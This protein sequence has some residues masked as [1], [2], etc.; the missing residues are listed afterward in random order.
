[1]FGES[2]TKKVRF[3]RLLGTLAVAAVILAGCGGAEDITA[4]QVEALGDDQ[5]L[6]LLDCQLRLA[7]DDMG[8]QEA[9]D[10]S[11]D[12][13]EQG[14]EAG[15]TEPIQVTLWNEDGYRC[16]EFLT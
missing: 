4:G 8:Q 3:K 14:M 7:A 5:A 10:Y 11:V 9:V 2:G 13:M 15:D 1:M 12:L 6:A 16:P